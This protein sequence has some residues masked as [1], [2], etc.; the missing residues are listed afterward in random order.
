M[1]STWAEQAP[2]LLERLTACTLCI[3]RLGIPAL[4]PLDK[5]VVGTNQGR[6]SELELPHWSLRR[7][8]GDLGTLQKEADSRRGQTF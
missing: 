8:R 3:A 5:K 6:H 4:L 2:R 7:W 1:A